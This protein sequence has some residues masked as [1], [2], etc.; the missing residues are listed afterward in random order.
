[1]LPSYDQLARLRAFRFLPAIGG[2]A[3]DGDELCLRLG[4]TE[5]IDEISRRLGL[6]LDAAIPGEPQPAP[7]RAYGADEMAR[8]RS[9]ATGTPW[10]QPGH[11]QVAGEAVFAWID[12]RGLTLSVS[13]RA[14]DPYA[15]TDADVEACA[16]IE[17]AVLDTVV[18]FVIDPPEARCVMPKVPADHSRG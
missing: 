15:V 17:A 11:T 14:G 6:R 8:L 9:L 16:R 18:G 2:H 7:G 5:A 12:A 4:P 13:G 10:V 3:N 1:M